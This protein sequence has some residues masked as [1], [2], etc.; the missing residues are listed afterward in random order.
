M[1]HLPTSIIIPTYNNTTDELKR[2][3]DSCKNLNIHNKEIIIVDDGSNH[4]VHQKLDT[5]P[6]IRIITLPTN[7][8]VGFAR[9]FGIAESSYN[10]LLFL[11]AD[12][13][14]LPDAWRLIDALNECD[15]AYG[16]FIM[17]G[18]NTK[19]VHESLL[20]VPRVLSR[21][22][23][24]SVFACKKKVWETLKGFPEDRDVY[25]DWAFTGKAF[26]KG[27]SFKY[28]D[29]LTFKYNRNNTGRLHKMD[30]NHEYHK[31]LTIKYIS[32][33]AD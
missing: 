21:N 33:N 9:N 25:E 4:P 13:E 28:V 24:T 11:D 29:Y 15:L 10:N 6:D 30:T 27:F 3:V 16:N 26:V 8:G 18:N 14:M 1:T 22:D 23:L 20:S 12:D 7:Y 2:A 19:S 17:H 31:Q 32:S 5:T